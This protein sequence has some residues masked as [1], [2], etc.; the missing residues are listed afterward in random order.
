[1]YQQQKT[2]DT[3][4][5]ARD[6]N[7]TINDAFCKKKITIKEMISAPIAFPTSFKRI[8][9]LLFLFMGTTDGEQVD[10]SGQNSVNNKN[11]SQVG[12]GFQP[13]IQKI[14]D[15]KPDYDGTGKHQAGRGVS[16]PFFLIRRWRHGFQ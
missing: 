14:A 16:G 8:S 15:G 3:D 5:G 7:Y 1:L 10:K 6:G 4:G 2:G 12:V 9:G 11:Y 13:F